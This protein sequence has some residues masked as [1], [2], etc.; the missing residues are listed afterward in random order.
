MLPVITVPC[1]QVLSQMMEI[2]P[3]LSEAGVKTA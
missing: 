1:K 2:R 3:P